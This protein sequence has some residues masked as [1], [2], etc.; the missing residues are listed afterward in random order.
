MS[1]LADQI[2]AGYKLGLIVQ[3]F[4]SDISLTSE[5]LNGSGKQGFN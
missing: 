2:K 5:V 3:S 4:A 1:R